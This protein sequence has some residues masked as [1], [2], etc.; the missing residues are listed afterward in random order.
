M[1]GEKS[2]DDGG[3]GG[4]V[5]KRGLTKTQAKTSIQRRKGA[6]GSRLGGG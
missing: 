1:L 2:G 6:V 4:F 3:G 5:Q